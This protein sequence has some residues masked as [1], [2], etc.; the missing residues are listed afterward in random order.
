MVSETTRRKVHCICYLIAAVVLIVLYY[1]KQT[2]VGL[3]GGIAC[4]VMA[5]WHY[6]AWQTLKRREE[7]A[8]EE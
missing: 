6:F 8:D 7:E 1:T 3:I 2:P 5:V 4:A